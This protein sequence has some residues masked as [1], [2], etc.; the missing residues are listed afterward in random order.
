MY[1][2]KYSLF[3]NYCAPTTLVFLL[4]GTPKPPV[5]KE[6]VYT[7]FSEMV[8][9]Q[10]GFVFTKELIDEADLPSEGAYTSVGTYDHAEMV[11]LLTLLSEKTDLTIPALL[12]A[13]GHYLFRTF[14]RSYPHFLENKQT[15]FPKTSIHYVTLGERMYPGYRIGYHYSPLTLC[16][17]EI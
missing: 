5:M 1:K 10:H 14:E 6:L 17:Y 11:E 12:R 2:V 13:Y 9:Q 8:E 4:A 16:T 15:T 3:P 7:E